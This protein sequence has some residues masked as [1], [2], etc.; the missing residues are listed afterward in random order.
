MMF[1]DG[2]VTT[3][4]MPVRI[5]YTGLG[6][7]G[8]KKGRKRNIAHQVVAEIWYKLDRKYPDMP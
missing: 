4:E 8:Q 1:G 3:G 6:G 7:E 5:Q 2:W